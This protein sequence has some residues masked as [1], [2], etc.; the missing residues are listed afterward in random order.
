M[1]VRGTAVSL[2]FA[3]NDYCNILFSPDRGTGKH[4]LRKVKR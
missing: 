4:L 1:I 2:T 3:E